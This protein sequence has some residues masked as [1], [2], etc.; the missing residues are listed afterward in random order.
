MVEREVERVVVEVLD[1]QDACEETS[2]HRRVVNLH[3]RVVGASQGGCKGVVNVCR[4]HRRRRRRRR[5]CL[6]LSN[7]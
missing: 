5:R 4:R 3:G 1:A 6:G 2:Y 7:G